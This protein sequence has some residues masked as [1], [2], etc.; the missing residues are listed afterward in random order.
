[1]LIRFTDVDVNTAGK[2]K[3]R[4]KAGTMTEF[5]DDDGYLC[6]SKSEYENWSARKR[7]RKLKRR[8]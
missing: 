5:I 1:M 8:D 6:F 7:G 2:I 3:H 4:Q